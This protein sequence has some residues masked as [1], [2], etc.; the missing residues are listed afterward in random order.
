MNSKENYYKINSFFL[1]LIASTIFFR[2]ICT[3]LIILFAV[4]N[5][6]H[7]KYLEFPKKTITYVVLLCLPLL[8]EILFFWN[9]SSYNAGLKSLEKYTSLLVFSVFILGNY[10]HLSF[11][12]IL[13]QYRFLLSIVL[14]VLLI[15]FSV[16]YSDLMLKYFNGIHLW[17]MGY[18]FAESFNNHAPAVN[19]HVAFLVVA[20]VYFLIKKQT[21]KS[22]FFNF[23]L[24][25]VGVFSLFILNTRIS[26]AV[27][28]LGSLIVVLHYYGKHYNKNQVIKAFFAFF[29]ALIAVLFIGFK[30]NPYMKEKYSNVTFAYMDKV[31]KLDEIQNP[32]E[33]VFN[34]FVTRVSIWKAA[35]EVAQKKPLLGYGSADGKHEVVNYFEK[36]NQKFLAKYKFPVHN[37]ILDFFV[38][39]GFLGVFMGIIFL[40]I[41]IALGVKS[42]NVLIFSF[43]LIFFISNLFDD[44]LIR[45]DG[46]VFFQIWTCLGFVY[47]LKKKIK[48]SKSQV[49][50]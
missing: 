33:K 40:S 28:V 3:L 34:A 14:T 11:F 9:N 12:K 47:F 5:F 37:Q 17:E 48:Q 39:F 7:I 4:Y 23:L 36:T 29:I 19:M 16:L 42:N 15:R 41:P 6:L 24:L 44:F 31:G 50:S 46:I 35:L 13:N 2:S 1:V 43:G 49:T 18:N 27:A 22:R 10:K 25:I 21:S 45:F 26:L 38:K 20:D 32:E 8:F 30:S